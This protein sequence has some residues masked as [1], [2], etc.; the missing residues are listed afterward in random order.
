MSPRRRVVRRVSSWSA[1]PCDWP[2]PDRRTRRSVRIG[3]TLM[4]QNSAAPLSVPDEVWSTLQRHAQCQGLSLPDLV[5]SIAAR[6][7]GENICVALRHH[8]MDG[9]DLLQAVDAAPHGSRSRP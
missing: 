4:V 1:I 2:Q 7:V 3:G 9:R 8:V 5:A 6:G